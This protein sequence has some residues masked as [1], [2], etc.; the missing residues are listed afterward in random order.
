MIA[1]SLLGSRIENH[2]NHCYISVAL[3][4]SDRAIVICRE[5]G[6]TNKCRVR[7]GPFLPTCYAY[8][9]RYFDVGVCYLFSTS[10]NRESRSLDRR[11]NRG[12]NFQNEMSC[13]RID[14]RMYWQSSNNMHSRYHN[15]GNETVSSTDAQ[16]YV[17][18]SATHY[19]G[20]CSLYESRK[21][22]PLL[23]K[24]MIDEVKKN[25]VYINIHV[26]SFFEY[27]VTNSD[28]KKTI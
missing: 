23:H 12:R 5:K 16:M 10:A 21:R 9:D 2:T 14:Q 6:L 7:K 28:L 13:N 8:I 4:L 18:S 25:R 24:F 26:P 3:L 11:V 22:N 15:F 27:R 1:E 19:A 20:P 17:A